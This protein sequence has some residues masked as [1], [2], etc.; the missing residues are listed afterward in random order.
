MLE[1]CLVL[2]HPGVSL[3]VS[4]RGDF[5]N[6]ATS[7]IADAVVLETTDGEP[8][9]EAV[10]VLEPKFTIPRELCVDADGALRLKKLSEIRNEADLEKRR[11]MEALRE[12]LREEF[13]A[14]RTVS[15]K[16]DLQ[17]M[18][19]FFGLTMVGDAVLAASAEISPSLLDQDESTRAEFFIR[20]EA[21]AVV[22]MKVEVEGAGVPE[23]MKDKLVLSV[24][25]GAQVKANLRA[26]V[27][28]LAGF[29][30]KLPEFTL[31]KLD[32]AGLDFGFGGIPSL[33][34]GSIPLLGDVTEQWQE[35]PKLKL[36]VDK[37]HLSLETAPAG[38]AVVTIKGTNVLTLEQVKLEGNDELRF[39]ASVTVKAQDLPTGALPD[40]PAGPFTVQLGPGTIKVAPISFGT[41]TAQALKVT[42]TLDELLVFC[43]N[44][45]KLTLPLKLAFEVELDTAGGGIR[46]KLTE[47]SLRPPYPVD[48]LRKVAEL[49]GNSIRIAGSIKLPDGPELPTPPLAALLERL[50]A[51]LAA[52][53]QWLA[54]K[55]AAAGRV[56]VGI[57]ESIRD[58]LLALYRKLARLDG[59][60]LHAPSKHL[61]IEVRLDAGNW[62]LR[63]ICIMPGGKDDDLDFKDFATAGGFD[64]GY[65]L[66]ARPSLVLDVQQQ[67]I[68]IGLRTLST[69]EP[70]AVLATDLWLSR[71]SAPAEPL[72][73]IDEESGNRKSPQVKQEDPKTPEFESPKRLVAVKLK[74]KKEKADKDLIIVALKQGE[75]KV[76]Q[77][78]AAGTGK[79]ISLG[80]DVEAASVPEDSRLID[81]GWDDFFELDPYV[82][83]GAVKDALLNLFPKAD[84]AKKSDGESFIDRL[85]QY[86]KV[87]GTSKPEV[88]DGKFTMGIEVEVVLGKDIAPQITMNVEVDLRTFSARVTG[89]DRIS[90]MKA[91]KY[92]FPLLGLN[93]E[94]DRKEKGEKEYEALALDLSGGRQSFGLG[95]DAKATVTYGAVSSSGRGLVFDVPEFQV[96]SNGLT[97]EANITPEPVT[98]GGVDVPF[99]FTSGGISI[100]QSKLLGGSLAGSGQLPRALIG[101]ANANIALSL[102]AGEGGGIEVESAEARLDKSGDPIVCESTRFRL[103]ITEL[104]MGFARENAYHFYF[105]LT[106]SARFT[107]AKG[108]A[109]EGL[110]KQLGNLEIQL[111]KAP[112][113]SDARVLMRSIS[114]Q[115]KCEPPKTGNFFDIFKFELRG[116][117]F[118]PSADAFGGDPAISVSG[119]VKFAFGDVIS[120]RI[121]CHQLYIAAPKPPSNFP[122]VRFDGLMVGLEIG[123]ASVEG[124]AIAVDE[125]LPEL[126]S[127]KTLPANVTAK[128]FLAA[129][130]IEIKGW[131]PMSASMGFLELRDK[132]TT[133]SPKHAFYFYGQKNKLAEPIPTPIGTLYLREVGFGFGYRYTLAGVAQAERATSPKEMI[134]ILDEVSK[135]QG[136]L[137][138]IRAWEPTY[139]NDGL[140]LAMRALFTVAA[141]STSEKYNTEAEKDLP[142][143]LLFDVIAAIRSDL[144]FLMNVRSWVSV[145]YADWIDGG[146]NAA[147]K[148]RPTQ[149]GYLYLSAPRQEFLGRFIA[150]G[151]GHVGEHPPLPETL[152]QAIERTRFSAT[153]YLRPGLFHF[154]LGWPFELGIEMGDRN[155]DFFI[156]CTGGLIHRIEDGGMLMGI[157][158]R[159]A[160]HARFS[161]RV[162]GDSLGASA[163]ASA[164]FALE[165]K[166]LAYLSLRAKEGSMLY[167]SFLLNVTVAVAVAV[168][169][170]FKVWRY[171]VSLSA[172]F[173]L[174]LSLSVAVE[175]VL[176]EGAG[177]GGRAHVAIGVQAFGRSLSLGIGFTFGS[178]VLDLARARVARFMDLGLTVD[179]PTAETQPATE[180]R[181]GLEASRGDRSTIA[182]KRTDQEAAQAPAHPPSP[183]ATEEDLKEKREPGRTITR[184]HFWALVFPTTDVQRPGEKLY[185]V[186]LV[187]RDHTAVADIEIPDTLPGEGDAS[188]FYASPEVERGADDLLEPKAL[189]KGAFDH[190][191]DF[192]A[193]PEGAR[194]FD[195]H[196][197]AVELMDG[198]IPTVMLRDSQVIA[199][200]PGTS[201]I[202]LGELLTELFMG[203]QG[204]PPTGEQQAEAMTEPWR[205][206]N[207]SARDTLEGDA[208][209]KAL[210]LEKAGRE[211]RM[212]TAE[213]RQEAEVEERRSAVLGAI[214][215]TAA[216]L[217][218]RGADANGQWP[219][220]PQG[221]VECRHFG[222]T[223]VMTEAAIDAIFDT[224]D[225]ST[226]PAGQLTVT[227]RDAPGAGAVHL[228][229]PPKRHFRE[230]APRLAGLAATRNASGVTLDWDLEPAW[231][232]AQGAYDDPEFHLAHYTIIRRVTGLTDSDWQAS[233]RVKGAAPVESDRKARSQ[234]FIRPDMQ[235][236]DDFSQ[237]PGMPQ[238]LRHMLMGLPV[239]DAHKLWADYSVYDQVRVEY[240]IVPVDV[241]GTSDVGTPIELPVA[242]PKALLKTP[243]QARLQVRYNAIP[244]IGW[245]PASAPIAV[246]LAGDKPEYADKG[247]T[248]RIIMTA[249]ADRD[250]PGQPAE[251]EATFLLKIRPDRVIPGGLFGDDALAAALAR[252]SSDDMDQ[253]RVGDV[254]FI[255]RMER[256]AAP[257]DSKDTLPLDLRLPV[258]APLD[259]W[260]MN[261][262]AEED[263]KPAGAKFLEALG[264]NGEAEPRTVR[265]FVRRKS[266]IAGDE[267]VP[268]AWRVMELGL[269]VRGVRK[270]L[271]QLA[272]E[273]APTPID[274]TLENFEAVQAIEFEALHQSDMHVESGRLHLVKPAA[275]ADVLA[276][277]EQPESKSLRTMQDVKRRVATRLTWRAQPRRLKP[278]SGVAP[279]RLLRSLVGGFDLFAMD[280]D[281]LPGDFEAQK[282]AADPSRYVQPLGRVLMLPA[283][284]RGLAPA[285]F[286]DLGRI[287]SAYPSETL[288]IEAAGRG[289]RSAQRPRLAPWFSPAESTAIFPRPL[290]RKSLFAAP[291]EALIAT[292]LSKGQPNAIRVRVEGWP[293]LA[294]IPMPVVTCLTEGASIQEELVFRS[295]AWVENGLS[296]AVVQYVGPDGKPKL[297][298][299]AARLRLLLQSLQLDYERSMDWLDAVRSDPSV[300]AGVKIFVEAV[301]ELE[302][303]VVPL[304]SERSDFSPLTRLHPVLADAL[305]F[306][307]YDE[308]VRGAKE[309]GAVYRRYEV[310]Y[311]AN[312]QTNATNFAAWQ[313]EAP[314]QRDPYGWGGLRMLGLAS[315]FRLYDTEEGNYV[316]GR[317]LLALVQKALARALTRYRSAGEGELGSPFLDLVCRPWG[318]SKLF[319][320]DGGQRD[321]SPQEQEELIGND[322][323]ATVQISLR[324]VPDG[325]SSQAERDKRPV[326]YHRFGVD[327]A[328]TEL[329]FALN[330]SEANPQRSFYD[331][332]E[333]GPIVQP[334]AVRIDARSPALSLK[335][336]PAAREREFIVRV[337]TMKPPHGDWWKELTITQVAVEEMA[338]TSKPD[339]TPS[340][341]DLPAALEATGHADPFGLFEDLPAADWARLLIAGDKKEGY[342]LS[343]ALDRVDFYAMRRF[344]AAESLKDATEAKEHV[345]RN[346]A[347]WRSYL[348]HG[349][350]A[351]TGERLPFSLGTLADPG[352]WR[353]PVLADGSMSVVSVEAERF[354]SR[355]RYAVRPF[356][357]FEQLATSIPTA[358][359]GGKVYAYKPP[360]GLERG[361]PLDEMAWNRRFVDATLP[362]TEPVAKPV[363]LAATRLVDERAL[364]LVVAHTSD[365]VL[366]QAN[367]GT[368]ARV[369]QHGIGVGFWREFPHRS[370]AKALAPD[371]DVLGAF[372]AIDGEIP[373]KDLAL[374]ITTPQPNGP[375][376]DDPLH[377]LRLRVP[378]AWMGSWVIR[379]RSLPYFFRIH[380][381]VHATAGVM[382][383][384]Q[385]GATF[386][387]GFSRLQ[388]PWAD[389]HHQPRAAT[390]SYAV[391]RDDE[392]R[393]LSIRFSF[394]TVRFID[395][396]D[397]EDV[398]LWFGN[399][400]DGIRQVVELPE[401]GVGYR[402]VLQAARNTGEV[403][404]WQPEIDV[405]A[406]PPQ[407]M[408]LI[409]TAAPTGDVYI[410][411]QMGE[412]LRVGAHSGKPLMTRPVLAEPNA[413]WQLC[414][415]ARIG[416]RSNQ[417]AEPVA[418]P[419]PPEAVKA[420][421]DLAFTSDDEACATWAAAA[422]RGELHVTIVKP[423]LA[424][425]QRDWAAFHAQVEAL[426]QELS[427]WQA[428]LG[429]VGGVLG[430]LDELLRIAGADGQQDALWEQHFGNTDEEQRV[431]V[432]DWMV[433]VPP[434]LEP[435]GAARTAEDSGAA[436]RE[437]LL[438]SLAHFGTVEAG[439]LRAFLH[440]RMRRVNAARSRAALEVPFDGI[441][442]LL[443]PLEG[444]Y[445]DLGEIVEAMEGGHKKV[446]GVMYAPVSL[447]LP[448]IAPELEALEPV[449]AALEPHPGA[450]DAIDILLA[451]A[452]KPEALEVAVALP[453]K[454][455][456]AL[457]NKLD[458]LGATGIGTS[459]EKP[460]AVVLWRPPRLS[461]IDAIK[462]ASARLRKLAEEQLFGAG[463]LPALLVTRGAEI[464]LATVFE[465][466]S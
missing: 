341:I 435:L 449:L 142:N 27:P 158:F 387:E 291:D 155:G 159:G 275:A 331:V 426:K 445:E 223:F 306:V 34:L 322:L 272:H 187:P 122:R 196:G 265:A 53:A 356:G 357:R 206:S 296:S 260:R 391:E 303:E 340:S 153:L 244:I 347:F 179:T 450:A 336:Q 386:A 112:L 135:Y 232:A 216:A 396:M 393:S 304:A 12:R 350:S 77:S 143:P 457:R 186:Q 205:W 105:L 388:L 234:K 191:V 97:L 169:L 377:Q 134:K 32:F 370:W 392:T 411:Q 40:I 1:K 236:A 318:N 398:E 454:V 28:R 227:K 16:K 446:F 79:S 64:F 436:A 209:A 412:R 354:G 444:E 404:A 321:P 325:F 240:L 184:T 130:R 62:S 250:N 107:P 403:L 443:K 182:D 434:L 384:E 17:E 148:S 52:A 85:G 75:V 254:Q 113:T 286:G 92:A 311:E 70:L 139:D 270:D 415:S 163:S 397:T 21:S 301:R 348:E 73:L 176:L 309:P 314:P 433:G 189:A 278:A 125:K 45:P 165:A 277:L 87:K 257:A 422:P 459:S 369:A 146:E 283:S 395:C 26:D 226:P 14:P 174:S 138:S 231:G 25:A 127:P 460:A 294:K 201:G 308:Q 399:P 237:P 245:S 55:A 81:A 408:P 200:Q 380:A 111:K 149:R 104:G 385:T 167:G 249:D 428:K 144:T 115:V 221:Q 319:W 279:E 361:L 264:V 453:V 359:S 152:K 141:A 7:F 353:V 51:M 239:A 456:D 363:I 109:T 19:T 48:L 101:E 170:R 285:G 5:A 327:A 114:F 15:I 2:T 3:T 346:V 368:Q 366:A 124:T 60:D 394:A 271:T 103:D 235:F 199:P 373:E 337:C 355:R 96:A 212:L 297:P 207:D 192:G 332:V 150:D 447:K 18:H 71:E 180:K 300:F 156:G 416:A 47:L 441:A 145:N 299:T 374:S 438:K 376:K 421:R 67:W 123:M 100:R 352:T 161:G 90:V 273:N 251:P 375:A 20:A 258:G 307:A 44:D 66:K 466:K 289:R 312:P 326:T 389:N 173:S 58:A 162:G 324:P 409:P 181:P 94:L 372:G 440:Q 419:W 190:L 329:R 99:K 42:I 213:A 230:S 345:R 292:L 68:G 351:E 117:G 295:E 157:A 364:E 30:L 442:A 328:A 439:T 293:A 33:G 379:A 83:V 197:V 315:G 36:V 339:D 194:R 367:R 268:G 335:L 407:D 390:P 362:R 120:S 451:W 334:K 228:F 246:K 49:V 262:Q 423:S 116:I 342:S 133:S 43:T 126:F 225:V 219:A 302:G 266:F 405:L 464:P 282:A 164:T 171:T 267:R 89:A 24:V 378:D 203:P 95:R 198:R 88:K 241:A 178:N 261:V 255:L 6:T 222:L 233:F 208:Q 413:H 330:A 193:L 151:K 80:T 93:F 195:E 177:I 290:L 59:P 118:H 338:T 276:L 38:K 74:S 188:T 417:L 365:Q 381:L 98:L 310:V 238:A 420:A 131:A 106:G 204:T 185:V 298:F 50:G 430:L 437:L 136:S 313:D 22:T 41:G 414:L 11:R 78:F 418:V 427:T 160:G 69:D 183:N 429:V 9:F 137:D 61:V 211:R 253:D 452:E 65:Q 54:D 360:Q 220:I 72:N 210:R 448:A 383:S 316:L 382:V 424:S 8:K 217:A 29:D 132:A 37:G 166:A 10:L 371:A 463:K 218:A 129:G 35:Q 305:D 31:P 333:I 119:Q 147:F 317:T 63:Q 287:E 121:D 320:F 110:L 82:N 46:T 252:P 172:G 76:F 4:L 462:E 343:P 214:V 256:G 84:P 458:A 401:P 108:E 455:D 344:G 323:L 57:G 247:P 269:E 400:L 91:G 242:R 243:L 140:T 461:E 154:E 259:A 358:S 432:G 406:S 168:W 402:I 56:L 202:T 229:N 280:A 349:D 431:R 102:I 215:E 39:S 281:L 23:E 224:R 288:R 248:L 465:Q 13:T 284:M 175:L 425:G 410:V 86:V 274:A 263:Q 128:G